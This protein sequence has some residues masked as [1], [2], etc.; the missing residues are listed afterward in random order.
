MKGNLVFSL[1]YSGRFNSPCASTS[2]PSSPRTEGSFLPDLRTPRSKVGSA[3]VQL[4]KRSTD[5]SSPQGGLER[6]AGRA[7]RL[8]TSWSPTD[9][10]LSA[11]ELCSAPTPTHQ[12]SA[13]WLPYTAVS[14][15]HTHADTKS[16]HALTH[17]A[18]RIWHMQPK[19]SSTVCQ[20]HP[21]IFCSLANTHWVHAHTF[22]MTIHEL[23]WTHMFSQRWALLHAKHQ[24]TLQ[25][26]HCT[27]YS[28]P[29]KHTFTQAHKQTCTHCTHTHHHVCKFVVAHLLSDH[30]KAYWLKSSL[31]HSTYYY[32]WREAEGGGGLGCCRSGGGWCQDWP[33]GTHNHATIQHCHIITVLVW[34]CRNT[35]QYHSDTVPQYNSAGLVLQEHTTPTPPLPL[36]P[37]ILEM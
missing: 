7:G 29:K 36:L 30:F 33:A 15:A 4:L 31:L 17:T 23:A 9:W 35:P 26:G 11:E 1:T 3:V 10:P 24:I 14:T 2:L 28:H 16:K 18:K 27:Y 25:S 32:Y 22:Y 6:A 19:R 20:P 21:T 37:H 8:R 12:S 13:V 5:C 34:Y